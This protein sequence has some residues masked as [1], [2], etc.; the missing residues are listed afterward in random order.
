MMKLKV[1]ELIYT[2]I[3]PHSYSGNVQSLQGCVHVFD[4]YKIYWTSCVKGVHSGQ[5]VL[6][7]VEAIGT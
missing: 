6:R 1:I 4:A 7:L 2:S 3:S 5:M